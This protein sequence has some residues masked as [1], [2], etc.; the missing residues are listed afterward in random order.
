MKTGIIVA[1]VLIGACLAVALARRQ[2]RGV[3]VSLSPGVTFPWYKGTTYTATEPATIILPGA[4]LGEGTK[5]GDIIRARDDNM[6]IGFT[7]KEGEKGFEIIILK[8]QKGQSV[9]L[10]RSSD[11]ILVDDAKQSRTFRK[12]GR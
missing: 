8:F 3:V 10:G 7:L 6:E 1:F 4:I 5:I 12:M 9:T 11:A 2:S